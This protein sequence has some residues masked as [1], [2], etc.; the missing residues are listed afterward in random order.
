LL[1]Y[2][3]LDWQ[4][5]NDETLPAFVALYAAKKP[6]LDYIAA[7]TGWN[8]SILTGDTAALNVFDIV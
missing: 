7:N 5:I 8:S 3:T 2:F 4:P 6:L 1:I